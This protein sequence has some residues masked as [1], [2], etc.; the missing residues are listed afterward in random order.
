VFLAD[1]HD[2]V[3]LEDE[4]K[5]G[6]EGAPRWN[7]VDGMAELGRCKPNAAYGIETDEVAAIAEILIVNLEISEAF[8]PK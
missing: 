2:L 3:A 8:D 6:A 5:F 7:E 1:V 4:V